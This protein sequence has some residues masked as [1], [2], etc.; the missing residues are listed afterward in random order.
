MLILFYNRGEKLIVTKDNRPGQRNN[1]SLRKCLCWSIGLVFVAA[2]ITVGTLI[3]G[4]I[5]CLRVLPTL[6]FGS[7]IPHYVSHDNV[8]STH[9]PTPC[10]EINRV[11]LLCRPLPRFPPTLIKRDAAHDYLK[12]WITVKGCSIA[13][14]SLNVK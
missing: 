4:K 7:L 8:S 11:F 12:Y 3:G 1:N 2:A 13:I 9:C 14:N 5:Q 6:G 10:L